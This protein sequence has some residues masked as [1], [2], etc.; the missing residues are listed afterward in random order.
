MKTLIVIFA[1]ILSCQSLWAQSCQE[2]FSYQKTAQAEAYN[3]L[4]RLLGLDY[5]Q[6][7]FSEQK[8]VDY[9]VFLYL[10]GEI[11]WPF[12]ANIT[13]DLS[14]AVM[15]DVSATSPSILRRALG[16]HMSSKGIDSIISRRE[17]LMRAIEDAPFSR[18]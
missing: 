14:F 1:V 11:P 16:N 17:R 2:S 9:D 10:S 5:H 12:T 15:A 8:R 3:I 6:H 18:Q 7:R 13:R 4:F